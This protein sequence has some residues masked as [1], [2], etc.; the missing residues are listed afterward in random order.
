M[1]MGN[2]RLIAILTACIFTFCAITGSVMVGVG[3]MRVTRADIGDGPPW[4]LNFRYVSAG[5]HHSLGITADGRLFAWGR[6]VDGEL[7]DGT[8]TDIFRC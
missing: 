1:Y 8:T 2:K 5:G 3:A 4:I 7:G 6:N